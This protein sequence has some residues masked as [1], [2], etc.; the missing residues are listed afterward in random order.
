LQFS[1]SNIVADEITAAI[2]NEKERYILFCMGMMV[3]S[4]TT[5]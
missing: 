1:S 5:N 3:I 2:C 4:Q